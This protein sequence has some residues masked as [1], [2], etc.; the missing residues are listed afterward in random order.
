M[1]PLKFHAEPDFD[2]TSLSDEIAPLR[3]GERVRALHERLGGR[4]V[5][6]TSFGLQSAVMLHLIHEHAPQVPVVFIDTGFLFPETY[7]YAEELM[8]LLPRLDLRIYQPAVS[9]A[10]MQALWGNLWEGD[11]ADQ[12]RYAVLTKIEPMNRALQEIGADVWLSGLRRAQSSTRRDRP[13]VERQKKTLKAYPILDW[14]DIQI[15]LYMDQNHLPRHPLA[16][17]GYLTTGD[18][19]STHPAEDGDA[20]ATRFNGTKYE[21]G[22]HLDSGSSDFQI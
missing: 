2:P 14:A 9:S 16:A 10:R 7:R 19:H 12:E 20:E 6:T 5:A 15:D 13:F 21:C 8:S 4:L 18:W 11:A 22:L 3:A 17:Q 1:Q